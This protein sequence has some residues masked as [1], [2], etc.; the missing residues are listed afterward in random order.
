MTGHTLH[1]TRKAMNT[2]YIIVLEKSS[3]HPDAN[4]PAPA[5]GC[6]GGAPVTRADACCKLDEDLK[7]DGKAGCGCQPPTRG[8]GCC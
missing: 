7:A 2:E 3:A 6:C 4:N 8:T 5:T 1:L